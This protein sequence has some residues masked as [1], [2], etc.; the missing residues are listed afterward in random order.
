MV[1]YVNMAKKINIL[2]HSLVP[3]YR[4]MEESEIEDLL[5]KYNIQKKN[6]PKMLVD[7]PVA[8]ALELKVGDVLE[9]V[10][11]SYTS[12]EAKYYRVVVNAA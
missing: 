7:D 12:G 6:L 8:K 11:K 3:K 1:N 10:R 9:I 2:E 4:L 5:T